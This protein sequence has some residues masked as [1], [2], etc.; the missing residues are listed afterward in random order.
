MAHFKVTLKDGLSYCM[1]GK[2]NHVDYNADR[3]YLLCYHI[4]KDSWNRDTKQLIHLFSH[5][6][7]K[8]IEN[9]P[10]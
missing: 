7:V 2:C 5:T 9:V 6:E 4:G 10:D 1:Q 3:D 8:H